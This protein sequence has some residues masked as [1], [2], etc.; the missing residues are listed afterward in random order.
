VVVLASSG[1]GQIRS[2][3][4]Q[5]LY[6]YR[7]EEFL[8]G[9]IRTTNLNQ[10]PT[11]GLGVQGM[12]V[13]PY[14]LT[15]ELRTNLF[16][17]F[18]RAQGGDNTVTGKQYT[19][20]YYDLNLGLLQNS[21]VSAVVSARDALTES[22]SDFRH[23]ETGVM[24]RRYQRQDVRIAVN[25][26]PSLPSILFVYS[27]N[28][29]YSLS[30][31]IPFDMTLHNYS[32]N[33]S[34]STTEGSVF[35]SGSINDNWDAYANT[36]LRYSTL[37][38]L[39][40][41]VYGDDENLNV[42]LDYDKFESSIHLNGGVG[43]TTRINNKY[44]SITS[45][46]GRSNSGPAYHS[47]AMG[48]SQSLNFVQDSHYR[49]GLSVSGQYGRDVYTVENVS[50]ATT[51]TALAASGSVQ[52]MRSIGR[53]SVSNGLSGGVSLENFEHARSGFSVGLSNGVQ[54]T[55]KDY[56]ISVNERAALTQRQ[57]GVNQISL[58]NSASADITGDLWYNVQGQVF[59]NFN[60]SH[61][62]G[63]AIS[64]PDRRD[65]SLIWRLNSS[66][67][68][69]IPFTIGLSG[70]TNWYFSAYAGKTYGWSLTVNSPRFFLQRLSM[71]YTLTRAYDY[72]YGREAISNNLGLNYRWRSV[73]LELRLNQYN[74]VDRHR[75]VWFSILRPF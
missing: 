12:V 13:S 5:L 75:E 3:S 71:N 47:V 46:H 44:S 67:H 39:G 15:F 68:S 24:K 69:I 29:D 62:A 1:Y 36:R 26:V 58:T 20:N 54:T 19:W 43:Y 57:D 51:G 8:S 27:R 63:S 33:L 70:S 9:D 49:Y 50:S 32:L 64:L 11:F 53:F 73:T 38:F 25:R 40:S 28:H 21:P 30:P 52:H 17:N 60:T 2:M 41:R 23:D 10:S 7:W 66:F 72:Y 42:D 56:R 59:V 61:F 18:S 22:S 55:V 6:Q 37:H 45:V 34:S 74:L 31:A 48:A 35:V 16:A 4:G 65:A 14:L